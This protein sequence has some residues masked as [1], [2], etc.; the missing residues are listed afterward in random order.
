MSKI[1]KLILIPNFISPTQ[2]PDIFSEEVKNKVK[3]LDGVIVE[4]EK[5]ARALLRHFSFEKYPS[6]RELPMFV[7]NEH[8]GITK[9]MLEMM[10]EG[11]TLGL[12]SD[13]GLACLADPGSDL[14][15]E[16]RRQGIKIQTCGV[17]SAIIQALMLSGLC[18]QAFYF[19]GYMPKEEKDFIEKAK[20]LEK[21]SQEEKTTIAFIET[22][23]RNEFCLKTLAKVLKPETKIAY[24]QDLAGENEYVFVDL[25]KNFK[26]DMAKILKEPTVFVIKAY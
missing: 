12:I 5:L 26:I 19:V 13:A 4:S 6:F 22:P 25:I 2:S 17:P 18:G 15:F 24:L 8:Q 1:G 14:I 11:K 16:A 3:T 20:K 9:Q 10:K 7:L 21:L 23:Y